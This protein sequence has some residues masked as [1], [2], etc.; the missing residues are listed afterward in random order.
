MRM[1]PKSGAIVHGGARGGGE[2]VDEPDIN[3]MPLIDVVLIV[4]IFFI[5]TTSFIP[6]YGV[7]I[8]RPVA[9]SASHQNENSVRIALTADN[10]VIF[11]G[12]RYTPDTL[13][14]ALSQQWQQREQ[15][16]EQQRGQQRAAHR[17]MTV[18][19]DA[20]RRASVAVLLEVIN[21]LQAIGIE[22][23]SLGAEVS[24]P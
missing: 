3:L 6:P 8:E 2:A 18:V 13:A 12:V 16:R 10:A 9:D 5:T 19:V 20:D 17:E 1:F 15:E 22:H 11:G 7:N 21:R 14:D 24:E 4:L 23:I